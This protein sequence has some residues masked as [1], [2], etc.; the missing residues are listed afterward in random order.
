MDG[1]LNEEIIHSTADRIYGVRLKSL[2][3]SPSAAGNG[4][5][6]SCLQV[7]YSLFMECV[8][9]LFQQKKKKK[10]RGEG[11][12]N[13]MLIFH[14]CRLRCQLVPALEFPPQNVELSI[15]VEENLP[16]LNPFYNSRLADGRRYMC[17]EHDSV[18]QQVC[19]KKTINCLLV[20]LTHMSARRRKKRFWL[21][22]LERQTGREKERYKGR[23]R[24]RVK[25]AGREGGES[26]HF[27]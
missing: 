20:Y 4:E 24:Y 1:S 6:L 11:G 14:K 18:Y 3:Y 25:E 27:L 16:Q 5:H 13:Y 17:F 15:I 19:S 9:V 21:W 23:E 10:N 26:W 22:Q 2:L 12:G 7:K 8:N